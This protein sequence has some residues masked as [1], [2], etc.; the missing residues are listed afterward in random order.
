[1]RSRIM[2]RSLPFLL[3]IVA[4]GA[5]YLGGLG[6]LPLF[7]RDEALYAEAARE[8]LA[9]GDWITP[10]VNGGPFFEKPPLYYWLA[11]ISFKLFGVSPFAAR[12]PAALMAMLTIALTAAV[13][14]RVWGRRAGLLAGLVLASS[15]QMAMIGRLGIMDVPLTCLIVLALIAYWRWQKRGRAPAAFC[16]GACA[17]LSVL[18]KGMAGCLAPGIALAHWAIFQRS[19]SR[20][21]AAR[22]LLAVMAF[23]AIAAPWFI[24]MQS[25]H[26]ESFASTLFLREHLARV[27]QPM[28]GHGGGVWYYPAVIAFSFFPW[29]M[30]L[31]AAVLFGGREEEESAVFWCTLAL[32]WALVV[33]LG[34]TLVRTKLPGYVT[35]LFPAMALL[36]G[37]ELDRRLRRP[38]R[39]PWIGVVVGGIVLGALVSFLPV[40][41][42]RV[43]ARVGACEEAWRLVLP[44]ALW[45]GGYGIIALGAGLALGG[46]ARAGLAAMGAGQTAILGT[47]LIGI[48][49]VLSPYLGGAGARLAEV[50]RQELPQSQIVLYEVRPETVAFALQRTLPTFGA[51]QQ[52]E[53]LALLRAG[54]S[55]LIAPERERR[56]WQLLRPARVW[57]SGDL[58]L[59]DLAQLES[60]V[61]D[62]ASS[63]SKAGRSSGSK[64]EREAWRR[65]ERAWWGLRR[66]WV[67]PT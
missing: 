1:M 21:G 65:R 64:R 9:S 6:R 53:L 28:Q 50:A 47:I 8:I 41:G 52:Q 59:L 38:G 7:G 63:V 26:G 57:R 46:R 15:L 42:A 20:G 58:V 44:S 27:V 45:V 4:S 29:V 30:L 55:A 2:V 19:A 5:L 35:P 66:E 18:M 31:P 33:L 56:F 32:V 43:G 34:F 48:L 51:D 61:P 10:R 22:V 60:S 39:G 37:A 17:G 12:L 36:V 40:A 54:P 62:T 23:A 14:A 25:R 67:K 16:L 11:A 49:P 24:V 3:L 13:G